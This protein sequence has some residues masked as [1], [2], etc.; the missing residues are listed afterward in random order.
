MN[1]SYLSIDCNQT[2]KKLEKYIFSFYLDGLKSFSSN[3]STKIQVISEI[4]I[5]LGGEVYVA[6]GDNIIGKIDY[7]EIDNIIIYINSLIT[8]GIVFSTGISSDV[9]GAY[10]ALKYAK[11]SGGLPVVIYENGEFREYKGTI[12]N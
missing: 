6:A 4:I 9:I 11:A 12:A 7:S 1:T 8:E 5:R 2:G 3:L 10:L